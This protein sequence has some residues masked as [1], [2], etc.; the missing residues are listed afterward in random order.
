[1]YME[2]SVIRSSI[3]Q[4]FPMIVDVYNDPYTPINHFENEHYR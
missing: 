4:L 2:D 3:F 1:M